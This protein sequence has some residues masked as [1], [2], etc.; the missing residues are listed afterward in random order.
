MTQMVKDA[1]V[2]AL[3]EALMDVASFSFNENLS[4]LLVAA[5]VVSSSGSSM[6]LS[7]SLDS[8]LITPFALPGSLVAA[9]SRG[10]SRGWTCDG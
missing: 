4:L 9:S 1:I 3:G 5:E 2:G 10:G 8:A 6:L 7:C